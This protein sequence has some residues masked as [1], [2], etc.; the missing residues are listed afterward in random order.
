MFFYGEFIM[1]PGS[2]ENPTLLE[3]R[4]ALVE[5]ILSRFDLPDTKAADVIV[6]WAFGTYCFKEFNAFPRL[7]FYGPKQSGKSKM[8]FLLS[9]VCCQAIYSVIPTVSTLYRLAQE[10]KATILLD[11]FNLYRPSEKADLVAILR[12]GY[13]KGA[14]VP[15]SEKAFV[16]FEEG[17]RKGR[18]EMYLV[19]EYEVYCPIAL[20]GLTINDDQ[21]LDRCIAINML[22]SDNLDIVSK[23]IDEEDFVVE[24]K[25]TS[26]SWAELRHHIECAIIENSKSI[27]DSYHLLNETVSPMSGRDQEVWFPLLAIAHAACEGKHHPFW[28]N[29]HAFMRD[30]IAKKKEED[31]SSF[32]AQVLEAIGQLD[33]TTHFTAKDIADILNQDLEPKE[34]VTTQAVGQALKRLG[35]N[36]KI[37][38]GRKRYFITEEEYKL[39]RQRFGMSENGGS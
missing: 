14:V 27:V 11:E 4:T 36:Y 37:S 26:M 9:K 6:A 17:G 31:L 20:A 2:N 18:K 19:A 7:V 33:L 1:A 38:Q 35:I 22:R 25:I 32:D 29:I 13:K 21:L 28:D 15:R 34:Q 24:S 5:Y 16:K 23:T 39:K 30:Y 10:K 12:Q 3:L 8:L